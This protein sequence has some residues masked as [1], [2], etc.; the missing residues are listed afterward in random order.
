MERKMSVPVRVKATRQIAAPAGH[1]YDILADYRVGHP[2]ILPSAFVGLVVEQGGRGAGTVIRFGMKSF[3]TVKWARATV[4]EPEPGRVL[5]ERLDERSLETTFTVDPGERGVSLVTIETAWTPRGPG[6]L[7]ER[8]LAPTFL[9][10]VYAEEL[11]NLERVATT[12]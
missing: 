1:V 12:T 3:G 8:L 10:R 2:R 9:K 7:L 6:S 11:R 4:H 5:L